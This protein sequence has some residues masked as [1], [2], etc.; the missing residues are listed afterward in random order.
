[1]ATL[2]VSKVMGDKICQY[3]F[4]HALPGYEAIIRKMDTGSILVSSVRGTIPEAET[5]DTYRVFAYRE[6][7]GT[8]SVEFFNG[9]GFP[10][11]HS[12][13]LFSS[14]G[15]IEPGSTADGRWHGSPQI[16]SN[17]FAIGD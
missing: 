13:Y 17:W 14:S 9:V 5:G 6:P 7:S 8:L 16:R 11:K 12:G 3:K 2:A 4:N 10:V 15:V 1:V